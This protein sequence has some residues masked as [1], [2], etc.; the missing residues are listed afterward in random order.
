MSR[1]FSIQQRGKIPRNLYSNMNQHRGSV[2]NRR[3]EYALGSPRR[4]TIA[5]LLVLTCVPIVVLAQGAPPSSGLASAS[6]VVTL[7]VVSVTAKPL[8][9]LTELPSKKHVFEST[10]S[11]KVIGK[12][13]MAV[14]GPAGGAAQALAVAPGVNIMTEGQTGAP[15]AS[16][17][18]NGMKTGWGNIAGNANDGTVMVT[19]DGV[20]MA[21]PAYG[22]WHGSEVPQLSMIKGISVT[23]GPGYAINRWYNNI[24]GAINF[25]PLQ[26]TAKAGGSIGT[27]IGSF[28]TH[29]ENF[30]VRTGDIGDGWSGI[31]AGGVTQSSSN[32]LHGYGA[33]N[34]SKDYAYYGK[35]IK[36]FNGGHVSFGAY[37]ESA[38]AYRPVPIPVTPNANVT[39]NGTN[40]NTLTPNPGPLYSQQTTGFYTTL[41]YSLYSKQSVVDTNLLYSNF[42]NQIS[43]NVTLHNLVWYRYGHRQHL[44]YDNIGY[45]ANVL[46]QYYYTTSSTYGDKMYFGIR[47]PFNDVSVGAY[48]L[49]SKYASLLEFY[50]LG[51]PAQYAYGPNAGNNAT[52]NGQPVNYS[53]ALPSHYH[54]SYLYMT[55]LAAFIQDNIQ[56]IRSIRV[57]PGIRFVSFQTNFVN[58]ASTLFPINVADQIGTNGDGKGGNN[59]PNS[60]TTFREVEP[61]IGIN[62][63]VA[64]GI[65]LYANYSTAYKAPAG[66]TGTYAHLLASSLQP[67]KSVQY[68]VGMKAFVPHDGFLNDAAFGVN[69]YKLSDTNEII[70]IPVVS[71]LYSLFASGSS[72]FSGVNMYFEDDPISTLHVFSNISFER[73]TYS[74]Y[75]TPSGGSYAG[76]PVSNVPAQIANLG[77]YY[78]I[79]RGGIDYSP[80]V[81]WQY[82]G[83]QNIY[84]NN[85][86]APTTQK[87]PAFSILNTSLKI[88]INHQNIVPGFHG[89]SVSVG[90]SNVLNK[91]YNA[92]EYISSGG[93]YGV[94]GE[95]LGEPGAPRSEYVALNAEF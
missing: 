4:I 47:L 67:Q 7:G 19:F 76:L 15:R 80:R 93:Y 22:V 40:P 81:W 66:A 64:K 56:P 12:K 27:F 29:G 95:L 41:P 83:A 11:V 75:T 20:P 34:P 14:A 79:T 71:H 88:S 48:Y 78:R 33:N 44:H 10:Q 58:N 28:G 8:N 91:Q 73:A 85:T 68:Q 39:V 87:L 94:A 25:I 16:I 18:I 35:L 86:N 9:T 1:Q 21:D 50:N 70:P 60:S 36:L 61:S 53:L 17:S 26:P 13:Q 55:N 37:S 52:I 82:T 63:R 62:W 72:T 74:N 46:N 59:Q 54:D 43:R 69:Y 30:N 6:S 38:Y 5:V 23:Y 51:L 77:A 49:N 84:N 24:G 2:A 3:H 92:Y 31:L 32:Y 42:V 90:I 45:E 57:T 89:I 65:A